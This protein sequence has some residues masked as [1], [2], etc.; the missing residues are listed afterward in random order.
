MDLPGLDFARLVTLLG[1]L[2]LLYLMYQ[3]ARSRS[4]HRRPAATRPGKALICDWTEMRLEAA[5]AAFRRQFPDLARLPADAA[6]RLVRLGL[7]NSGSQAIGP[8]DLHRPVTI[9]FGGGAE[10][11]S[12]TCTGAAKGRVDLAAPVKIDGA[13][14]EVAPF[15]LDRDDAAL[16]SIVLRGGDGSVDSTIELRG[17]SQA[18]SG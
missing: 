2:A 1:V 14:I 4:R 15:H 11:V 17:P 12:A 7:F 18:A 10:V 13:S 9:R 8:E 3:L 16:F 6:L 5:D